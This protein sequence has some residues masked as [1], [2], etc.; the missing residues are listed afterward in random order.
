MKI[1][2]YEITETDSGYVI[3][4]PITGA[5][6]DHTILLTSAIMKCEKL[7]APVKPEPPPADSGGKFD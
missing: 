7:P 6:E 2:G 4:N 3:T 5:N 1:N